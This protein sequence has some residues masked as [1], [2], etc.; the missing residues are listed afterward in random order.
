[1]M[2]DW[3]DLARESV[4]NPRI[5]AARLLA[6]S[7]PEAVAPLML[8]L[9]AVLNGIVYGL[10]LSSVVALSPVLLAL[11]SGA[12]IWL[13]AWLLSV[14]GQR[15]GGQGQWPELLRAVLWLQMLRL[16]AQVVLVLLSVLLPPLAGFAGMAAGVW[17]LYMMVCFVTEAHGFATRWKAVAALAAVFVLTLVFATLV[18]AVIGEPALV[19]A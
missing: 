7:L 9:L 12:I 1:M 13:S 18:V 4:L 11:F 15:L 17:G 8:A 14:V 19:A 5:G 16:V 10:I 2:R 3:L 6:L